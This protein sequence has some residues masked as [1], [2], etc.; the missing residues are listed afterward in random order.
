MKDTTLYNTKLPKLPQ[1]ASEAVTEIHSWL[2]WDQIKGT[3]SVQT[4]VTANLSLPTSRV[5]G[6]GVM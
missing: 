6:G 5:A 2:V 4:A 3:N 1:S